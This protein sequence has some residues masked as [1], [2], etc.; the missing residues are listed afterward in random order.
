MIDPALQPTQHGS[1][2]GAIP[3]LR[4]DLLE[5]IGFENAPIESKQCVQLTSFAPIQ[6]EPAGQQQPA[7]ASHQ[8]PR[9]SSLTEELSPSYLIHRL[10]SVLQNVEPVVTMRHWGTHCCRLAG[11]VPHVDTGRS[12]RVSLKGTQ[13]LLEKLKTRPASVSSAPAEPQPFSC[14][15][16]RHHR[17]KLLSL[18][19]IDLV[20]AH[21]AQDRSAPPL[22]PVPEMAQVDGSHRAR[23]QAKL[24]TR[25][26]DAQACPTAFSKRRLT[27]IY[28]A[29]ALLS[30]P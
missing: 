1:F 2:V 21:L 12:N 26:T 15:Q 9:C 4:Q 6:V 28:W 30:P 27:G 11:T 20:D 7:L 17:Q 22:I 10:S 18:P 16:F 13:L 19:Q 29:A 14:L 3:Q 25:R 24:A 23:R 5:K 8:V